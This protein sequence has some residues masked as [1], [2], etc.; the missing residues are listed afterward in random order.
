MYTK[1]F[2]YTKKILKIYFLLEA[3][4]FLFSKNSTT[5]YTIFHQ[6]QPPYYAIYM[7]ILSIAQ[8]YIVLFHDITLM[9]HI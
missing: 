4:R 3:K 9:I 2:I 1:N 8:F 7:N 6:I 5:N